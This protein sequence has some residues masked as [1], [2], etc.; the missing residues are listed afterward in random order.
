MTEFSYDFNPDARMS[1]CLNVYNMLVGYVYEKCPEAQD[2]QLS[3]HQD[4]HGNVGAYNYSH[5]FVYDLPKT[6]V[7]QLLD[8]HQLTQVVVQ[9]V[10]NF[11][12][13]QE[14]AQTSPK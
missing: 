1:L 14:E 5:G 9:H 8:N 4:S 6:V 12:Q 10:Q 13:Q 2:I 3:F 7:V 11:K